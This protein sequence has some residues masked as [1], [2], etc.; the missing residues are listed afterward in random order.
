[1]AFDAAFL[2]PYDFS[3]L[4]ILAYMAVL[5]LYGI[6]ILKLGPGERPGVVRIIAF[7]L[8]VLLCYAVMQT[9][10]DYYAQYMF[11]IHRGQHLI[12]HHLGPVL[13]ALSNPLPVIRFWH[14]RL[15]SSAALLLA[16]LNMIYRVLQQPVIAAVL[17]VGLIYFWLWPAVHFDAMLSRNLYW[18][19][20][21]SMLID[22]LL[23]WWLILDPRRPQK[24]RTLSYGMRNLMLVL[25]AIPQ[26]ALGAWI[27]FSRGTIYDVYA[28]CGR[29]W[30]MAA[31]TDQFIGGVLTWVPPAM[32]SIIGILLVLRFMAVHSRA[33]DHYR[34][35]AGHQPDATNPV[36]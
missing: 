28:V 32:M 18:V 7:L 20:N 8:G 27:A 22:G 34:A 14:A 19:M 33:D 10:Y 21:W 9:R 2:L 15:P 25:V 23:F 31:E 35:V 30:P 26:I 17:F 16:P 5:A 29:A 13:I 4:T 11:F 1:M 36:T 6:A 12:L 3:P 24:G